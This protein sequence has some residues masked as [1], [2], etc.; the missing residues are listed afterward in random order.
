MTTHWCDFKN[1]DVIMHIGSNSTESHP[2]SS[3]WLH[4]AHENG[5]KWI[6]IDPRYTRTAEQADVFSHIRPGTDI[7]FFG[8]MLNYIVENLIEPNLDAYLAGEDVSDIYNFE[9]LINYTNASYLLDPDY[10]FDPETGLFSGWDEDSGSYDTSSW[11]YQIASES[12]W[13]TSEDGT[14]AW[15]VA[16]GVP[17][18]TPPTVETPARDTTLA[19]PMCV[20][21]QLKEHYSRY[22]MDTVCSI[23][24]MERDKLEEIYSIYTS[25]AAAGKAGV[26]LYALGQTQHTYG[27]QNTRALSIVQLML[28]NIGVAGGG[29]AALRGEPNVQG[30]TDMGLLVN[31]TPGYL[32]WPNTSARSSLRKWL[33]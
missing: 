8:G 13:D 23:C 22:D 9:Y 11:H 12:E 28:G 32:K 2:L 18:F 14:Y 4:R 17:E 26:L 20:Y 7:S 6:V 15:A 21:Q 24:G 1:T 33:E 16:E 19:D 29:V 30:A 3:K 31:E 25:T 27:A 10:E 5:A